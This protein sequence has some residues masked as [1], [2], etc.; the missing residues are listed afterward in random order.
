MHFLR[1]SEV[2]NFPPHPL[3]ADGS[4]LPATIS[5]DLQKTFDTL[6]HEILLAKIKG[7]AFPSTMVE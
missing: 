3:R 7:K 1:D 5:M 6:P 2:P 4:W